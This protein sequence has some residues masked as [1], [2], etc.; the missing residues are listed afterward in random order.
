MRSK[1]NQFFQTS[2]K[3]FSFEK[4]FDRKLIKKMCVKLNEGKLA[5][6]VSETLAMA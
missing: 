5:C 1:I 4:Q 2:K 6:Q 3:V